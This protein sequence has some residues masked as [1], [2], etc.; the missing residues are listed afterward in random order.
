MAG[1]RADVTI[2]S[3]GRRGDGV[4]AVADGIVHVPATAPGDRVSVAL[5]ETGPG[6]FRG[7]LLDL[8]EAG[9]DRRAPPLPAFRRVRRLRPAAFDAGRLW[10]VE[11]GHAARPARPQRAGCGGRRAVAPQS[12][13]QPAARHLRHPPPARG[14]HRRLQRAPQPSGNRPR[15]LSGDAAGNRRADRTAA[16]L[17]GDGVCSPAT[18]RTPMS[19]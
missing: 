19:P 15:R 7:R 14:R 9:P 10:R 16:R 11:D 4:A 3:I 1:F 2:E 8:L 13:G 17:G 6:R 5:T 12:A 18:G